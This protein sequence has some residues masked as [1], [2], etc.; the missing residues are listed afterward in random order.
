MCRVNLNFFFIL[1]VLYTCLARDVLKVDI[2]NQG[3]VIGQELSRFR[4]Q[5]II[6][7]YGIPYAQPPLGAYRFSPPITNPLPNWQGEKNDSDY[8]PACLQGKE[9]YKESELPLLQL[10]A[11]I[12]FPSNISED[13]LY[14][15]VFT[16]Q[17]KPPPGGFATIIW[18]HPGNFTTGIPSIWDP[19]TVVYRQRVIIVTFSWRLNIMGFFTTMDGEAPGNYGLMD[20]QAAMQWVKNNI[21][22]FGGNPE[23]ICIMGYGT[24]AT[25]IGIHMTNS[26]SRGLFNKAIAMSANLFQSTSVRYPEEDKPIIDQLVTDFGCIRKP[27]SLFIDCL[28]HVDPN[29]LVQQTSNVNWRPL[30]DK[31]L[32]HN[33]SAPFLPEPPK[34]L[35]SRGEF[36]RVPLLTG[37]TDMEQALEFANSDSFAG[38]FSF[39]VLRQMLRQLAMAD[40]PQL[41]DTDDSCLYNYDHIVDA[42]MFFY[43]PTVL[44][45]N[46]DNFRKIV[47]NFMLEKTYASSTVLLAT[48]MSKEQPT[49]VYRFDMKPT[50][51]YANKN[52]PDWVS[53]P[54]LFDLIYVWGVPYWD[55]EQQWDPRDKRIS[56]TIMSFWTNF[57]KNSDPTEKSIYPVKWYPFVQD[58]P[59]IL[60]IDNNFNMSTAR[61]LNY[62]AFEFWNDFYPKVFDIATQCC[63]YSE[64]S[65]SLHFH[66]TSPLVVAILILLI[67]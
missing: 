56:D 44:E 1:T 41:N 59:K 20:Q 3:V 30:I 67:F 15:N 6:A 14:L 62:K 8:Q 35:F 2:P 19:H 58:N 16:P 55:S 47:I 43:S 31:D 53:V 17:G 36:Q 50:T 27:T 48:Y 61:S 29:L 45:S 22:L 5:K 60:I 40:V 57:A 12:E 11:N 42:A 63:G 51:L 32:S 65:A 4:I 10:L 66:Q 33:N 54:H 21:Q 25:S 24:G 7:F 18:F 39:E 38:N 28:R 9:D 64:S 26:G 13:C 46:P 23:N 49:Y 37:Y 34:N 52:I